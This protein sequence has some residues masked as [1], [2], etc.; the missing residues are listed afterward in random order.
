MFKALLDAPRL[1]GNWL[2]LLDV[3]GS[4]KSPLSAKSDMTRMDTA[5]A[6]A[7]ILRQVC[8]DVAIYTFSDG[9]VEVPARRGFALAAAIATSQRQSGT[10]LGA[11]VRA[12]QGQPYRRPYSGWWW[13]TP[14]ML[15]TEPQPITV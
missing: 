15:L 2:L 8:E 12:I 6:L 5:C 10:Y 4:M 14:A 1:R 13:N 3:S 9:V 11:A 7:M